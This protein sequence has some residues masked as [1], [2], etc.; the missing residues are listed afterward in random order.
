ME[1]MKVERLTGIENGAVVLEAKNNGNG[2]IELVYANPI[3]Y[4]EQNSKATY[5]QYE[6][7]SGLTNRTA[8]GKS[9]ELT[10]HNI[11]WDEVKSVSGRTYDVRGYLRSKGFR[12]DGTTKNWVK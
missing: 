5:A 11:N 2:N 7:V 3:G 8:T 1:K 10:S 9:M 6:L 12:F 4:R